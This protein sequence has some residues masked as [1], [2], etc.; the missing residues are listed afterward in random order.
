LPKEGDFAALPP[1]RPLTGA[2]ALR[3][4]TQR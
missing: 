3:L 1:D 2:E 4:A